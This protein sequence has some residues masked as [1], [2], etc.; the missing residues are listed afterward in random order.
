MTWQSRRAFDEGKSL[1]A[2]P[3]GPRP[4]TTADAV[5]AK[6]AELEG[7]VLKDRTSTYREGS[8]I[9]WVKVKDSRWYEREAWRFKRR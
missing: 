2:F 9:G 6:R 5:E 7:L 3:R 8:R 4:M 1:D